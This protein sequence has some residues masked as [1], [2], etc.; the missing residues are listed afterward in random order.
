M[1]AFVKILVQATQL[2]KKSWDNQVNMIMEWKW[3]K[4]NNLLFSSNVVIVWWLCGESSYQLEMHNEL[5][6]DE[7]IWYLGIAL[8]AVSK[9]KNSVGCEEGWTEQTRLAKYW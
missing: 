8:K 2:Q 7:L 9:E 4:T 5:F 1:W 3:D 6:K